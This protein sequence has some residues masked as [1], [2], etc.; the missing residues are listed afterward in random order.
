MS[1]EDNKIDMII[2]NRL[3]QVFNLLVEP[4]PPTPNLILTFDCYS[5]KVATDFEKL[6]VIGQN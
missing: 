4:V 3:S 6:N 2:F 1:V 5:D